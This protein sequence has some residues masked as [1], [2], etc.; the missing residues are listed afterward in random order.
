MISILPFCEPLPL[1]HLGMPFLPFP[2]TPVGLYISNLLQEPFSYFCNLAKGC[3]SFP[4]Y[5]AF[6]LRKCKN[7]W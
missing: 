7:F 2:I 1:L 6:L 4:N 5:D 3:G